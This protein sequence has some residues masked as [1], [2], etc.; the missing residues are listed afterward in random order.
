M[1]LAIL[2]L[3][4]MQGFR[5]LRSLGWLALLIIPFLIIISLGIFESAAKGG[6]ELLILLGLSLG[7]LHF[8]RNDDKFLNDIASFPTLIKAAEYVLIAALIIIIQT[9]LTGF[10]IKTSFLLLFAL[11]LAAVPVPK[12]SGKSNWR[13]FPVHFIPRQLFEW[14]FGIR[15]YGWLWLIVLIAILGTSHYSPAIPLAFIILFGFG[16][17]SWFDMLEPKE[18]LDAQYDEGQF[19]SRKIISNCVALILV[20]SIPLLVGVFYWSS[21]W[22]LFIIAMLMSCLMMAFAIFYKYAHYQNERVK[23]FNQMSTSVFNITIVVPLL[24][25]IALVY[26]FIY[27]S[28]ASKNLERRYA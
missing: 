8:S 28:K 17:S 27:S 25:I 22:Y 2:R 11:V 14:R 23:I 15:K 20:L 7:S 5:I 4:L 9:L 13:I 12:Y 10:Q 6:M 24:C 19:L 18:V 3:R 16:T 1:I 26:L 21:L